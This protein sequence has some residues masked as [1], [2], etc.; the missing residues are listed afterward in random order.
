MKT[1]VPSSKIVSG[2][3]ALA[4]CFLTTAASAQ[5]GSSPNSGPGNAN[6]LLKSGL[7]FKSPR[8]ETASNTDLKKGAVYL[9]ED[10]FT[11]VDARL[12]IDSL[13]NGAKVLKIDDNSGGLGYTDALQPEVQS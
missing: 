13:V 6:D 11:G 12:S 7:S 8:L 4:V 3:L 1:V 9:F 10:V 5:S 2:V